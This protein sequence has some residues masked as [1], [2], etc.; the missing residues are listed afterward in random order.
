MVMSMDRKENVKFGICPEVLFFQ[1]AF[2]ED[3]HIA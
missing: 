2:F 1:Q 3:E